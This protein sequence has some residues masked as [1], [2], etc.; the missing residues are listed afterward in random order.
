VS[1]RVTHVVSCEVAPC[2]ARHEGFDGARAARA[3]AAEAGWEHR[4]VPPAPP[5][6]FARFVDLCPV[7][8]GMSDQAVREIVD[9]AVKAEE[10]RR[11]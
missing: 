8:R 3:S 4:V 10:S 1:V 11:G 9:V 2:P 6:Q 5:R 7:H